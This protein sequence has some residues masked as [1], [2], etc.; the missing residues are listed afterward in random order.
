MSIAINNASRAVFENLTATELG[1]P[2][3]AATIKS[4]LTGQ[5][6]PPA[7][8]YWPT[9]YSLTVPAER[10]L[11]PINVDYLPVMCVAMVRNQRL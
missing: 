9:V 7:A 1:V 10:A 8:F 5:P 2:L 6:S 3:A 11:A 4:P